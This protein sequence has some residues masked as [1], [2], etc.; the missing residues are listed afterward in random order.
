MKSSIKFSTVLLC[1]AVVGCMETGQQQLTENKSIPEPVA[2]DPSD[3]NARKGGGS[4][5][6]IYLSVTVDDLKLASDGK[7]TYTNGIDGISAQF[8]SPDGSLSLSTSNTR[9]KNPRKLIFPDGAGYAINPNLSANY[10]LNIFANDVDPA[11]YKM[12]D[13]P[14]GTSQVMAM[15]IWGTNSSGTVEFRLIYNYGIGA[16]YVTDKVTVTR[17]DTVTW[18]IG[19]T[20]SDTSNPEATAALT[21]GNN[22]DFR[23]Y[24]SVPF[25]LVVKRIN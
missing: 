16:G 11:P 8:T 18:I 23:G 20:D 1:L 14:V 13:I 22:K 3:A 9:I 2:S 15:R 25:R 12:Q 7:G 10:L 17:I 4:T 5:G 19:S 21:G 6:Q 24:Y